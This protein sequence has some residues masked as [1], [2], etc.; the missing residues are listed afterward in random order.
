MKSLPI[1]HR[2]RGKTICDLVNNL[3]F[4]VGLN[5]LNKTQILTAEDCV[6]L[7]SKILRPGQPIELCKYPEDTLTTTIHLGIYEGSQL[8]CTGT[9]L[10]KNCSLFP[11]IT[12]AY[13]LRGMATDHDFQGQG[14]GRELLEKAEVV[15]K[16]KNCPL[17][18]FNARVSA[19]GF[20][21]KCGFELKGDFFDIPRV[22]P[23]KIMFKRLSEP[24][25][26]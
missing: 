18:W 14:L 12:T 11:E 13:Q 21:Q 1:K 5:T 15:L 9:L 2:H 16:T 24:S 19:F 25:G 26:N 7:R 6:E 20:Y 8:I 23:H 10:Q 17:F 3:V 22:G 4:C